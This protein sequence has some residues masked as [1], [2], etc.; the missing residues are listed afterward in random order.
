MLGLPSL[1]CPLGTV[2]GLLGCFGTCNIGLP[3]GLARVV[4]SSMGA[5]SPPMA[6]AAMD[7]QL[8]EG[9]NRGHR[10]PRRGLYG[11]VHQGLAW[12][13]RCILPMQIGLSIPMH[14]QAGGFISFHLILCPDTRARRIPAARTGT[15]TTKTGNPGAGSRGSGTVPAGCRPLLWGDLVSESSGRS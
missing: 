3:P 9:V 12:K 7:G 11:L 14:R 1:Y 10:T 2:T 5:Q 4:G 6:K 8:L 15:D 13:S